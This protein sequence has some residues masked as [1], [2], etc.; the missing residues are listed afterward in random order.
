MHVHH[1]GE[2]FLLLA[3]GSVLL[4]EIKPCRPQFTHNNAGYAPRKI[5]IVD[6]HEIRG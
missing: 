5:I 1:L 3:I 4:L 2:R 6:M